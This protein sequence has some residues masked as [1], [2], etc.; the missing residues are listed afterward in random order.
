M[1]FGEK[2]NVSPNSE[3]HDKKKPL[4]IRKK[5]VKAFSLDDTFGHHCI[6]WTKL[7]L[8]VVVFCQRNLL[9][10]DEIFYL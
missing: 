2:N 8:N 3:L 5:N 9:N 4:S 7:L 1:I 10:R 6:D